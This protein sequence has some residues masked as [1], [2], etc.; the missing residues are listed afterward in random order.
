MIPRLFLIFLV[1]IATTLQ[2]PGTVPVQ[3]G[4]AISLYLPSELLL[5]NPEEASLRFMTGRQPLALYSDVSG[6]IDFSVNRAVTQWGSGDYEIMKS[7]YKSTIMGLYTE[8]QFLSEGIRE[9]NGRTFVFFEF[10]GTI[11]PDEGTVLSESAT[12]RYSSIMYTLERGETLLFNFSCPGRLQDQWS[13]R[14][15][16]LMQSIRI[17]GL[18]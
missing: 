3:I 1:P 13:A 11:V 14:A 16:E 7:F 17:S 15:A 10:L 4:K 9:A 18:P 2:K 12:V 5:Q 6:Q 8:V